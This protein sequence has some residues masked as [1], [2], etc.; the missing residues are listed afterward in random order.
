[1]RLGDISGLWFY[2]ES[3]R[4]RFY[5]LLSRIIDDPDSVDINA[6]RPKEK[7]SA[8]KQTKSQ[9][10]QKTST[11]KRRSR[12]E[13][14][15]RNERNLSESSEEEVNLRHSFTHPTFSGN[16]MVSCGNASPPRFTAPVVSPQ[17][18]E[19]M[20]RH[21][22]DEKG[23]IPSSYPYLSPT[24]EKP[25]TLLKRYVIVVGSAALDGS[26]QAS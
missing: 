16:G 4:F 18:M 2:R 20:G 5:D 19:K 9:T 12:K 22:F 26:L 7:Q 11:P 24:T 14:P 1:M 23:N 15:P 3:E 17:V 25:V 10:A 21:S 8:K 6:Y 13:E